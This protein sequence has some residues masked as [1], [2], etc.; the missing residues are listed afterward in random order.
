M[1]K[2]Y[3]SGVIDAPVEKVWAYA[4]D[5]NGH[6]EWHPLIAESHVEEGKP[7]DQVGCVRNFTLANGGKL[8]EMLLTFSDLDRFFTYNIIVSPMPIKDYIATFRCKPITEGNKTFVEWM[9]EFEVGPEHE[10]QIKQQVGRDTFAAGIVALE[11][12]IARR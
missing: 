3:V 1:A 6:H 9:A 7:S 8:R 11:K 2:V 4:R 5:F 10:A 12:A